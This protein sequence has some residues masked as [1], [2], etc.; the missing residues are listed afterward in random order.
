MPCTTLR[1]FNIDVFSLLKVLLG[2]RRHWENQE[3]RTLGRTFPNCGYIG[4][5]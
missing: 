1:K 3:G 4:E 2:L 5:M